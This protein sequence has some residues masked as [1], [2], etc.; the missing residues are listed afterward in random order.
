[1][2][3]RQ[4]NRRQFL[5]TSVGAAGVMLAGGLPAMGAGAEPPD[6]SK[7]APS[8]PVSVQRCNSYDPK[9]VRSRLD[10]AI[11]QVGGLQS[12]V[13]N[14]TVTIKINVTGGPG[15]LGGLPGFRTYHIHPNV[16]AALCAMLHEAGA[17]RIYVVESQ[18]SPKSP[19]EVLTGGGWDITSIKEA[20]A[21]KVFFE[22]T[23]NRGA[24]N[25]YSTL[26]VPWGGWLYPAF[27]VNQRYEKT[28]VFISLSKLKDHL[29]AGITCSVKNL[30]GIT[31]TSL[32]ANDA[33]NENTT[34]YRGDILH[35]E[36]RRVPAGVPDQRGDVVLRDKGWR[37]RVPRVT[38]DVNGARPIHL[39]IVD[40]VETNRGGEGP[41]AK[42]V[43][44]LAPKVLVVGKNAVCTDAICTAIM[45]YDPL[46][47]HFQFPFRGENHLKLLN[48]VGIGEIDP[49]QIEVRGLK[50]QDAIFPFNPN[51]TPLD[52]P[53][54]Y[55][56]T[57]LKDAYA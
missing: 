14:K 30:F 55:M 16:L 41:W 54:A 44:P 24:F 8:L 15:N 17:K 5:S 6:R 50:L 21:H 18:Y 39:A 20:G 11:D 32:Y 27:M 52:L 29:C 7:D 13:E 23:R 3:S 57:K 1:M 31:P 26:K 43:E 34:S 38:A 12:L 25:D 9:E 37:C 49:R 51:K 40:G 22:D 10:A 36:K 46:A 42:G 56:R 53:G 35:N 33:P 48:H 2:T 47:D 45:G 28:D 19:E 4:I